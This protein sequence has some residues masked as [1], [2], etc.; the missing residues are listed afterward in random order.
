MGGLL[1]EDIE[2]GGH[3]AKTL[4]TERSSRDLSTQLAF[5]QDT[6]QPRGPRTWC[7]HPNFRE[8]LMGLDE[9]WTKL[10]ATPRLRRGRAAAPPRLS[11]AARDITTA[12]PKCTKNQTLRRRGHGRGNQGRTVL[13]V[14]G[15][16]GGDSADHGAAV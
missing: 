1:N 16:P 14:T 10:G 8:Y 4:L 13:L 3:N 2:L 5:E 11:V 12:S 9:D 7:V 15:G 6:R